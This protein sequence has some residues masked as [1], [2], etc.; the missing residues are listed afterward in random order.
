MNNPI[1]YT[2]NAAVHCTT[3][4]HAAGMDADHAED[5]EGNEVGAIFEWT[6]GPNPEACETCED[7]YR[8]IRGEGCEN[9]YYCDGCHEPLS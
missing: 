1:G 2:Y 7:T 9:T 5:S 3:C 4:A 8:C 6:E